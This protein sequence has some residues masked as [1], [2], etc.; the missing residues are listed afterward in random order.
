MEKQCP[1]TRPFSF[2]TLN[3]HFLNKLMKAG[4]YVTSLSFKSLRRD[5][6]D[7]ERSQVKIR[8]SKGCCTRTL[9]PTWGPVYSFPPLPVMSSNYESICRLIHWGQHSRSHRSSGS[10]SDPNHKNLLWNWKCPWMSLRYRH[11]DI[12][13]V[14]FMVSEVWETLYKRSQGKSEQHSPPGCPKLVCE[15]FKN[16]G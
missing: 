13:W 10:I 3:E 8:S 7:V 11:A 12:L 16:N 2:K 14:I 4:K 5:W 15:S 1:T 9:F 6:Q